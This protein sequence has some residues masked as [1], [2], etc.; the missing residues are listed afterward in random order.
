M[1][2]I[3]F[4][5]P[6]VGG[7]CLFMKESFVLLKEMFKCLNLYLPGKSWAYDEVN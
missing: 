6:Q 4:Q 3:G 2:N 7:R 1:K 5:R